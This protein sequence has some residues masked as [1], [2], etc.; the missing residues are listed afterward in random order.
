MNI[1]YSIIMLAL[2][3]LALTA[4]TAF[5][6]NESSYEYGYKEAFNNY[7]CFIT[8]KCEQP[9]DNSANSGVD[10]I[11]DN[12]PALNKAAGFSSVTITNIT[13]CDDGYINGWKDWCKTD[14]FNCTATSSYENTIYG[15]RLRF[16]SD[17]S[18]QES[19]ASGIPINVATFVSPTGPDSNPTADVSIYMD[20]LHN[21][22]TTLNNYAHFVVFTDYENKTSYFRAFKL[23][24][25][26]TN[27]TLAGKTAYTI[28]GTYDLPSSGL[29]KLIEIGTI[30][31]DNAYILQYIADAPKYSEYLPAVQNMI[32]SLAINSS[33]G[34]STRLL[35]GN[36]INPFCYHGICYVSFQL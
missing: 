15:I 22:T 5:A 34:T 17:W 16:P 20:K 32:H 27:S 4:Q 14:A 7:K 21:S 28:I 33:T 10:Y 6:T 25:L 29:Q 24:E 11:C 18:V 1:I 30:I 35:P 31:R 19:S 23:L 12:L 36:G 26:S 9:E 3:G 2:V 13:A 8:N